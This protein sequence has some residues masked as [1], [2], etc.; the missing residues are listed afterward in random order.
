MKKVKIYRISDYV[1]FLKRILKL[2]QNDYDALR[3]IEIDMQF[4]KENETYQMP[5]PKQY[6]R[7][8]KLEIFC[9]K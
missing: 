6:G 7:F 5:D 8:N 4:A 9:A 2:M 1:T 3:E